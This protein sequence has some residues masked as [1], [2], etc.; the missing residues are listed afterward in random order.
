MTTSYDNIAAMRVH[1]YRVRGFGYFQAIRFTA[2]DL[3][4]PERVVN[5]SCVAIGLERGNMNKHY[6][7]RQS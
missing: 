1:A 7:E 3:N 2:N 5:Y 4:V 6:S